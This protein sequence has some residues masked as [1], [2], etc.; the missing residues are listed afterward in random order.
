[1]TNLQR[2]RIESALVDAGKIGDLLNDP[3]MEGVDEDAYVV[4]GA[5]IDHV[6]ILRATLHSIRLG[7]I[8]EA[9]EATAKETTAS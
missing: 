8:R 6:D 1:M 9:D 3:R 4:L 7:I 2:R 5:I